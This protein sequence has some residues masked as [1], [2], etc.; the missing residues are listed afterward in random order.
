MLELLGQ[1]FLDEVRINLEIQSQSKSDAR[2]R[3]SIVCRKNLARSQ[4]IKVFL[5]KHYPEF[6]LDSFGIEAETNQVMPSQIR[7]IL[8]KWNLFAYEEGEVT[9]T[10]IRMKSKEDENPII[11]VDFPIF[12]SLEELGFQNNQLH[13][14]ESPMFIHSEPLCDPA[15]FG[16]RKMRIELAKHLVAANTLVKSCFI[17]ITKTTTVTAVLPSQSSSLH[18]AIEFTL[19]NF[20]TR[21][22][23]FLNLNLSIPTHIDW[24]KFGLTNIGFGEISE[25][26]NLVN[27]NLIREEPWIL[28]PNWEA[29]N[30]EEDLLSINFKDFFDYC[31][32]VSKDVVILGPPVRHEG[33]LQ[34]EAILAC[35]H[36]DATLVVP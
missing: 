33:E 34:L 4:A 36:A 6:I 7:L 21:K 16:D 24:G 28:T 23:I 22:T 12:Q 2:T 27:K 15:N 18:R 5:E 19:F 35:L 14:L 17:K 32:L 31:H 10:N 8:N 29:I 3:L 20:S 25:L 30:A 26:K 13:L 11:A 9:S 1:L